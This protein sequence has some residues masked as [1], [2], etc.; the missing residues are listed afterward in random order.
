MPRLKSNLV[1][2]ILAAIVKRINDYTYAAGD[3]VSEVAIAEELS[4]SRTPVREAILKLIEYGLLE[5]TATKV[6]VKTMTL[7]DI[8][9][10]LEVREAIETMSAKIIVKNGGLTQEEIAELERINAA[11]AASVAVGDFDENFTQDYLFHDTLIGYCKN[12][13]LVDIRRRV[14]IQSQRPRRITIITPGRHIDTV[15]EH[16]LIIDGL[17]KNN[18]KAAES[19]IVSHIE[20]SLDNYTQILSD[21]RWLNIMRELKGR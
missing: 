8:A 20:S 1:D 3:V 10:I 4:V 12:S 9:E 14:T 11:I 15:K 7:A 21:D 2:D 16:E 18:Y 5:R 19:A 17:R 13:R 6:V